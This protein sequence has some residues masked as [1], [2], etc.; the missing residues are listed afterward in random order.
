MSYH[1]FLVLGHGHLQFPMLKLELF[2]AQLLRSLAPVG[3][4]LLDEIVLISIML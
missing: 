1:S 2:Q 4:E 3:A